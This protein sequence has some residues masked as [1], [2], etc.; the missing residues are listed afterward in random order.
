MRMTV[1]CDVCNRAIYAERDSYSAVCL[2][3][4]E[5]VCENCHESR[6]QTCYRCVPREKIRSLH[7]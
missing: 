1:L 2:A 5:W 4:S 7:G 6:S 3:C